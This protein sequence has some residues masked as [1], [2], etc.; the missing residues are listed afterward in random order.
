[1][2]GLALVVAVPPALYHVQQLILSVLVLLRVVGE[3]ER[4]VVLPVEVVQGLLI[5]IVG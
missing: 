2:Q 3:E 5:V 4:V 1:M